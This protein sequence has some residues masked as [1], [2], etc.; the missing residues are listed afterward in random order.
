MSNIVLMESN[1]IWSKINNYNQEGEPVMF[2]ESFI[3]E[4]ECIKTTRKKELLNRIKTEVD[5]LYNVVG[6]IETKTGLLDVVEI[7]GTEGK[8][9]SARLDLFERAVNQIK[10]YRKK[11]ERVT[12][13]CVSD[14]DNHHE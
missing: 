5:I 1:R 6:M 2:D 7:Q 8:K 3:Q 13:L 12:N 4:K 11:V 14:P 9:H 10:D